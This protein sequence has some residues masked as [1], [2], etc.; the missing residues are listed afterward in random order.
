[1]TSRTSRLPHPPHSSHS[2][3]HPSA[4][5]RRGPL[6]FLAVAYLGMWLA[7]APLLLTGF[8]RSDGR[9]RMSALTEI[10]VGAAMF[11]PALAALL[12]IRCVEPAGRVRDALALRFP[13]PW[14]RTARSCLT[15]LLV[16][17]ALTAAALAL[18]TA[19]GTY[20]Y[21][22][23]DLGA[24]GGWAAGTAVQMALSLPLFFGEELGWQGYLFPRLARGRTGARL[25]PAYLATGAAFA[26][27]HLPTLLMGGQYLD[28]P[29]YLAVP[30]M[31]VSCTLIL[32]VFTWLRTRSGSV[33]PAVIGHAFVSTA[34]VG[35]V[36]VFADP[37]APL[38]PLVMGLTGW[39]GWVVTGAFVAFLALTGRLGFP[40]PE[41]RSAASDASDV[42]MASPASDAPAASEDS[43]A[44]QVRKA[45]ETTADGG[46]RTP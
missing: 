1:M 9:A 45:R 8:H 5:R 43:A 15:A 30:A 19:T 28:R 31:L 17:G 16:P 35:L 40:S 23:A 20:P 18:G 25:I 46:L 21:G 22:G 6:V 32:P 44:V 10:C 36:R 14:G 12:V 7:M 29:W 2:P 37:R 39:P 41:Q 33:V 3:S 27:W 26:L 42:P 11:A 34:A 4:A 38:D 24:L 13:R